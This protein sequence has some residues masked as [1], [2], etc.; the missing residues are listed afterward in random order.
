MFELIQIIWDLF[1]VRR[2][3]RNGQLTWRKGLIA[4][5]LTVLGYL[6]VIPAAVLYDKHPEY[7]P[8]FIAA[9]ILGG[10]DFVF[11]FSLGIYWWRQ[12]AAAQQS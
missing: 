1:M 4:V 11:L 3:I 9:A 2:S 10:L 5:G 6:I 8:L 12:W 7:K